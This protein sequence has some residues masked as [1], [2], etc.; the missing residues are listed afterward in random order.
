MSADSPHPHPHPSHPHDSHG[1]PG[2]DSRPAVPP[3]SFSPVPDSE[4]AGSVALAEALRSSFF[5]VRLVMAALVVYFLVSNVHSVGTQ[6]RAIVLRFGEPIRRAGQIE[7]GPG[8]VWAFPY[9]IDE[10]VK[11]PVTQLQTVRSTVG[12]YAVSPED[13]A[14]GIVPDGGISLNPATEGY[15]I[16]GDGN[17][18]HARAII[19]YLITDPVKFHLS[20]RD[21]AAVMTNIVDNAVMFA[22][23][24]YPVDDALRRDVA[25]F[26]EV[27]IL[28]VKELALAH[29]LGV[30][31][32]ASDVVTIPPREVKREFDAVLS[33]EL[34]RAKGISDAQSYSNRVVNEARGQATALINTGETDRN[35]LVQSVA[36]EAQKFASLLPEYE[37]DPGF[38]RR[39]LQVQTLR[40]ILTNAQ[41]TFF[42]PLNAG[43]ELRLHLNREPFK[44]STNQATAGRR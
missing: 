2:K 12:W 41:E 10:V 25:G 44:S 33:A 3:G 14:A 26:K 21:G 42:L 9:P 13:E 8:L 1:D 35:R 32:E 24:R 28:R 39:Q 18:L 11:I 29:D 5:V 20:H 15:A 36:A 6:E 31:I 22:A 40:R 19:R 38:F 17:I 4:D 43:D 27:V 16:T 30:T 7:Q 23:A 34:E 37:K